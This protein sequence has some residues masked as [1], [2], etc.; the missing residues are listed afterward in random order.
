MLHSL[1]A[2]QVCVAL[3]KRAVVVHMMN[4]HRAE[5]LY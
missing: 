3:E 5:E 1:A 4:Q 2:L